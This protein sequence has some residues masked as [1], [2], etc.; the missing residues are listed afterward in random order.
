VAATAVQRPDGS[1][2]ARIPPLGLAGSVALFGT[3][4]LL[5]WLTTQVV[6]P[7]LVSVTD[8]EPV[9]LW[10]LAA[11]TVLFVPLLLIGILMLYREQG[12]GRWSWSGRLRFRPMNRGD[13]LWTAGGFVAVAVGT[14]GV[15][16]A[17]RL[18]PGEGAMHPSFMAFAPLSPGRY[19]IL[20]A[21]L[22]FFVVNI[23][24]EEF[25]WRGV[26]L[27]RQEVAFGETAWAVNGILWLLFHAVFPWQVLCTLMPISLI[28]PY[29]AQRRQNT[30]PG[31]IIHAGFGATGFLALAFGVA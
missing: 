21:W 27:P 17:L 14:G 24:G 10:F 9:L 20:A 28:L 15:A 23:L 4:A 1:A 7:A 29:I 30:W 25:L 5:L 11:G 3:G 2:P 8:V 22:P 13:W 31:V 16:A 18:L 6:I 12:A 26:V 19:W